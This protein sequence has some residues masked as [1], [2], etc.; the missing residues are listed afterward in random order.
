MAIIDN[1]FDGGRG[2]LG[3]MVVYKMNGMNIMRTKPESYSDQKSPAQ[4]AQRKRLQAVNEFLN[5]FSRLLKLTFKA[6]KPGQTAR[7]E[8]QSYNMRNALAGEH[9]HIHVDKSKALLSRG[10]LPVPASAAV[11]QQPDGLLIEWENDPE[12]ASRHP[13]DTLVVIALS[14]ENGYGDFHFTETRRSA[15]RYT[16]K[17]ALPDGTVDVWIAFRNR[18]QTEMSD[19]MWVEEVEEV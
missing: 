7:S 3:K 18:E 8:A 6:E 17:P 19:S 15:G 12:A 5:P 1:L 9:P 4:M 14:A 13:H 10:P 11:T 16:W 2:R